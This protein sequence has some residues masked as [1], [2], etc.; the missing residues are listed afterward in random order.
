MSTKRVGLTICPVWRS[1]RW[2]IATQEK[3]DLDVLFAHKKK[4][5]DVLFAHKNVLR[6]I[7][8]KSWQNL[9]MDLSSNRT[10]S[11]SNTF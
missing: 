8:P 1:T 9:S 5:M 4:W 2:K 3:V 6:K 7:S 10:P 11:R